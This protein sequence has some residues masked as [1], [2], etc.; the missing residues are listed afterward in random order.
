MTSRT[1]RLRRQ[2]LE[3]PPS[4]TAERA[5]LVT[6]FYRAHEGRHSVPVMR[7]KAFYHLCEQK[8]VWIGEDELIVGERGPGPKAVPTF[9]ELTCH[10]LDDLRIL[11][12]RAKT[13]YRVPEECLRAYEA[14]VIPYWHG[15]SM[16]D[17]IFAE[18]PADWHEAYGA[19]LFTE[20]M[21]QRAPGHTVLD[22]KIYAKGMLD[23]KSEIV[24]AIERLDFL[25][26]P[27]ALDR[28][29]AL[30]SFD[31]ACDAVMLYARRHA[32]RAREL[33]GQESDPK[34]RAELEKI[35][36]VCSH[37]PA[38]A[39]RDFQEAIQYYWFCHLAVITE[40]NGWDSF[41]PG[42]LDQHLQPFFER[43]LADGTL[44]R[45]SA[46]E[47]LECLFVKFN[48]HPAPPKVGVTAAESGTYTD[49]ANINIGGLLPDGSDGSNEV[50]HILLD[51]V[52]EMH[53]LQPSTNIQL[54][55]KSPDA[56][57]EHALRVLRKGYGFPSLFNADA[58]VQEQ[59][60]QGKTLEDARAGGC[61]GCV[62]VGAFGKEAY[63][64][65]GY[66][67]MPKVFE[68]ALHNGVDSKTG[69]R[70]GPETGAPHSFRTFDDLFAAYRA[71]FR[72]IL[73]IK[74]RGNQIIQRMYATRMPAPFLS[75]L[76]D[77]C[78]RRGLD[79]NAGGARY[80][81][82][83]IQFVGLGSLTDSLSAVNQ[84]C[85][86]PPRAA[87]SPSAPA[88][89]PRLDLGRLVGI[90][91]ADFAGQEELRQH[92]LHKMPRYGNDDDRADAIMIRVFNTC[93]EELDGR[94]DTKGGRYRIEMLPTTC[95]V[96]FGSVTGASPDGRKAGR[97]LSEGISPVQGADRNGPT[98]V[99]RSA[100]KMD[101]IKAGGT[102]LNMKFAPSL[103]ATEDALRKWGHLVRSYFKMDGHHVQF[104]VVRAATLRE[105]QERP[106]E[107]R[108][109]IVR[110][111]G[112]SDYFCDL[113][114]ELQ[115][116]I[117]ERTEHEGF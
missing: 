113:S 37:V 72:H 111:A 108:D 41:N 12:S 44:T 79:Y 103:V 80:N 61:S 47:L 112:Y 4:L 34:R 101:H 74:L 22:G 17:R 9:P 115:D 5:V 68:L 26:D 45:A 57:L 77:D 102:L 3:T 91:D 18:L 85:F 40:L 1:E 52:D 11:D 24:R 35:A 98:A 46:R 117:I 114:P 43:G 106:D 109:L 19:G 30:K 105:A 86:S 6:A 64:L 32:E 84:L 67:N 49:F 53:L 96:Y 16:R 116:E 95:H 99:I 90:L 7:A 20:F 94:P 31:I 29:E 97:P 66:F 62:E 93:V 50:S 38:H 33:A 69:K 92:L 104:N 27:L 25:S 75:V 71:Q 54:S 13:W 73:E 70:L 2:S 23:F 15:R 28:L 55:R 60:R 56:L 88:H 36:A 21:E 65:T 48:N 63:I 100:A 81:N 14:D 76:T 82:T 78:I 59:L 10:S 87:D 42:H 39:P 110:V 83:Y 8:A 107:H 51:I 89:G 58:V